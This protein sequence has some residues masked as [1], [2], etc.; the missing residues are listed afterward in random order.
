MHGRGTDDERDRWS[1]PGFGR[2]LGSA[3]MFGA[4]GGTALGIAYG[5][6]VLVVAGVVDLITG[7]N[8][9]L[10]LLIFLPLAVI[11]GVVTGSI[12]GVAGGLIVGLVL[13]AW[14]GSAGVRGQP[15]RRVARDARVMAGLLIAALVAFVI[16][17][18]S[19]GGSTGL[20]LYGLG[21]GAVAIVYAVWVGGRLVTGA[22]IAESP[23]DDARLAT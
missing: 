3:T 6:S 14:L 18:G 4:V 13:A 10:T 17:T 20:V 19:W 7:G 21:P 8:D 23:H 2:L 9:G 1:S 22:P 11:V 12:A 5:T 15:T 16:V